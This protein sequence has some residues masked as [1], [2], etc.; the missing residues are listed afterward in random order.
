M[1]IILT[2]APIPTPFKAKISSQRADRFVFR[3][4][5]E[6][7]AAL[8]YTDIKRDAEIVTRETA[9]RVRHDLPRFRSALRVDCILFVEIVR[10]AN[11]FD[12]DACRSR[13]LD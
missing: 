4:L 10:S 3:R 13:F 9:S 5:V 6:I 8:K 2:R 1:R 7:C 12:R 11:Y